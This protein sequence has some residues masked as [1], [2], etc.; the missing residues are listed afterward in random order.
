MRT[1]PIELD[2]HG[3]IERSCLRSGEHNRQSPPLQANA[4]LAGL[5]AAGRY[6]LFNIW[7]GIISTF[8]LAGRHR[9][10]DTASSNSLRYVPRCW[11]HYCALYPQKRRG[12]T[13]GT[14]SPN[15]SH[16]SGDYG[17]AITRGELIL[18]AVAGNNYGGGWSRNHLFSTKPVW[19][20]HLAG[21]DVF[22]LF[23]R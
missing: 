21:Q 6:Y 10:G 19:L 20:Y 16:F 9:C 7:L 11:R 1:N 12:I 2:S 18:S 14:S 17:S 8:S 13:G 5:P 22:P 3:T 4:R 23:R 15:L